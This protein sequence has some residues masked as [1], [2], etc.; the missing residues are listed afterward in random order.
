MQRYKFKI[1]KMNGNKISC[2]QQQHDLR[3]LPDLSRT[4]L[5]YGIETTSGTLGD[6]AAS[7]NLRRDDLYTKIVIYCLPEPCPRAICWCSSVICAAGA[8]INQSA[9][10]N[11]SCV[12]LKTLWG[13][14]GTLGADCSDFRSVEAKANLRRPTWV[15]CSKFKSLSWWN[16]CDAAKKN[17]LSFFLYAQRR[18]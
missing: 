1:K 11:K 15:L 9:R 14:L 2:E 5:G 8:G 17:H 12:D 13:L 3:R 4:I 7:V 6:V 16:R 18:L 10:L